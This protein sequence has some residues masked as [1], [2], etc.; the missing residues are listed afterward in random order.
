[1][2]KSEYELEQGRTIH[3]KIWVDERKDWTQELG[4]E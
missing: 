3:I 2:M 4:G 1:M